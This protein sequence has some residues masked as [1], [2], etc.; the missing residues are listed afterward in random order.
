MQQPEEEPLQFLSCDYMDRFDL[1]GRC[2][3][4]DLQITVKSVG[5]GLHKPYLCRPHGFLKN[6]FAAGI[7]LFPLHLDRAISPA[8]TKSLFRLVCSFLHP[9]RQALCEQD[10][11]VIYWPFPVCLAAR[12]GFGLQR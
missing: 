12:S 10:V 6:L 4:H 9:S 5:L 8:A 1:I 7:M 2:A 3:F 11:C